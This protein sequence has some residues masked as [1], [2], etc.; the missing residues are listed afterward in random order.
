M[1]L[2]INAM[3]EGAKVYIVPA[4]ERKDWSVKGPASGE[5]VSL[6]LAPTVEGGTLEVGGRLD[7]GA[8]DGFEA[9]NVAEDADVAFTPAAGTRIGGRGAN[10]SL[11]GATSDSWKSKVAL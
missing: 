11:G 7:L 4:G 2:Q 5:R 9:V 10:I 6:R 8:L 1:E 3:G